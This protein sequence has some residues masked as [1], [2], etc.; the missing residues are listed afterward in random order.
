VPTCT[1]SSALSCTLRSVRCC[2]SRAISACSAEAG[3]KRKAERRVTTWHRK[4]RR[5]YS[6]GGPR[7][8]QRYVAL[9][10]SRESAAPRGKA[11][12]GQAP[13]GGGTS[14]RSLL[15]RVS[16]VATSGRDSL[17]AHHQLFAPDLPVDIA[18]AVLDDGLC[19]RTASERLKRQRDG[20]RR[21][22]ECEAEDDYL[23]VFVREPAR[24]TGA[25]SARRRGRCCEVRCA[26]RG[27]G[28]VWRTRAP[29][30]DRFDERARVFSATLRD[31]VADLYVR[32]PVRR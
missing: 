18:A 29:P 5:R 26:R 25:A 31:V 9:P 17:F 28:A 4:H 19:G 15:Q 14:G 27:A 32:A 20:V 23:R 30:T 8:L 10:P 11:G 21:T 6:Q 7:G 22:K 3:S 1:S 16:R 12:L 13:G 24:A 2:A